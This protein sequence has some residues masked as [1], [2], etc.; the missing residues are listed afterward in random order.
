MSIDVRVHVYVCTWLGDDVAGWTGEAR[1][2][3]GQ[4]LADV[5]IYLTRL[6]GRQ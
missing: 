4:E 3:F 1:D 5:I 6:A 2:G